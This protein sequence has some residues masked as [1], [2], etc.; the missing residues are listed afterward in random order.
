MGREIRKVPGD[1]QHPVDENGKY[2]P[3]FDDT[4]E[5]DFA[6]WEKYLSDWKNGIYPYGQRPATIRQFIEDSGGCPDPS[7]YANYNGKKCT[8]YILY[9]N[10]SEGTPLTPKF[11][12]L[13]KLENYLVQVGT[14]WDG[15]YTREAAK[16]VC[17]LKQVPSICAIPANELNKARE[18]LKAL[19]E[20]P[21]QEKGNNL[22]P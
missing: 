12:S 3:L 9:E 20:S 16:R 7:S 4:F 21:K 8:H 15:K 13:E 22:K 14:R 5:S 6:E 19:N 17:K 2:L 18:L 11:D 10:V 1:W